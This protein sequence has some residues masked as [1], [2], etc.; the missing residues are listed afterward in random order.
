MFTKNIENLTVY[1]MVDAIKDA[2]ADLKDLVVK[3]RELRQTYELRRINYDKY[4][5]KQAKEELAELEERLQNIK[6]AEEIQW[7][8][9]AFLQ[10]EINKKNEQPAVAKK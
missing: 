8:T 6:A 10:D 4:G 7:N 5:R 3:K 9:I 1:E 2:R